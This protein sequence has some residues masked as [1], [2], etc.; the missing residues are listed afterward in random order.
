[1]ARLAAHIRTQEG[2]LRNVQRQRVRLDAAHKNAIQTSDQ[3]QLS[4]PHSRQVRVATAIAKKKAAIIEDVPDFAESGA[5]A[6]RPPLSFNW[7][8]SSDRLVI[9][10]FD[11]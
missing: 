10:A 3:T 9:Y 4:R 6:N 1:M 7:V 2:T 11:S 5:S 8:M